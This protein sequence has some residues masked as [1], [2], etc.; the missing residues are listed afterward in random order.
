VAASSVDMQ[1]DADILG[2]GVE[3]YWQW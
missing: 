1:T 3:K 2:V